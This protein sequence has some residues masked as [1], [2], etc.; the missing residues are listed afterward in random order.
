MSL[1]RF[2]M[3][4]L[5]VGLTTPEMDSLFDG[6]RLAFPRNVVGSHSD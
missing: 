2:K 3:V 1:Y 6:E 5:L 4:L